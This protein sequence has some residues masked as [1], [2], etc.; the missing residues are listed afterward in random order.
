MKWF[1]GSLLLLTVLIF[2][3]HNSN[4]CTNILVSKGASADGS[5]MITYNADAGG[6]MEPIYFAPRTK[7]NEGDKVDIYDWDTQKYLG[8][9]A[10]VSETYH[11]IGHINEYQVSLAETTYGGR[12]ELRDTLGLIDYGSLMQLALQRAKTAREAITIMTDLISEYGYYSS[13][14]SFSI[15]DKNE[16]WIM[17]LIGKGPGSKG[18]VW[19][20]MRVPDGFI[21]AHANRPRIREFP[22]D[23]PENCL[24]A[25]DVISF[26]EEK[27]YYKKSDGPFRFADIYDPVTPGS[28][29]FCEGRVWSAFNRAAPSLGLTPDYF[30]AYEGAE[31]YPL[32]I[33]PDEKLSVQDVIALMRDHFEDTHLDMT[34]GLAAG[35][36][37]CPYRW[38]NLVWKHEDDT[39]K[40]YGWERP[41]STQQTA[42]AFVSQLR[43]NLPDPIGGILWYGVDDNYSN[44]Y[45]PIYNCTK[46]PP[47]NF[48]V[49]SIKDFTL[50]S[51]FWV[52][53]L[54]A[55]LAYTKY[56]FVIEDIQEVQSELENKYFA[57]QPNIENT[58]SELYNQDPKLAV[59]FLSDYTLNTASSLHKRWYKLWTELVVKYNDGYIN[60]VNV[61][62]G[63]HP[64]GVGYGHE[65]LRKVLQ[66]RPGYYDVRWRKK[67]EGAIQGESDSQ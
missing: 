67:N 62:N 6:F 56:M 37:G 12:E 22:L 5:V 21:A 52:F 28:L 4:S 15:A 33:K 51:S 32:F 60:D 50:E 39:S 8:K 47:Y 26:A 23:D 61:D 35:P 24:Y 10:Q 54:V 18:A 41:I 13:G 34:E 58:A 30:M 59:D 46:E 31:P 43:S 40:T 57:Y 25:K 53:N 44:V 17:D 2:S 48:K 7:W 1:F 27:G 29:L 38:K 11:V 64:K 49:G 63:R 42:F 36:F 55:N 3:S 19:V 9:I 66:E 20:A 65:F 45:M 14:E 16:A